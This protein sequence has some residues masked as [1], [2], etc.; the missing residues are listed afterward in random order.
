MDGVVIRPASN[1][2]FAIESSCDGGFVVTVEAGP[3]EPRG[4]PVV[5]FCDTEAEAV[6]VQSNLQRAAEGL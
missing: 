4:A 3:N 2:R 1:C 6:D 5:A